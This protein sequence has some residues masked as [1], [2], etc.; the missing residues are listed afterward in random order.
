MTTRSSSFGFTVGFES[1]QARQ[2]HSLIY[3]VLVKAFPL[4]VPSLFRVLNSSASLLETRA[5]VGMR[6]D[7]NPRKL[8]QRNLRPVCNSIVVLGAALCLRCHA[9]ALDQSEGMTWRR[10]S[11]HCRGRAR[12]NPPF[13]TASVSLVG[14]NL[15]RSVN[16]PLFL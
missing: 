3:I 15:S 8:W 5:F 10:H 2:L 16:P 13:P 4:L 14:A 9:A 7:K 12:G 6:I 1:L 11:V